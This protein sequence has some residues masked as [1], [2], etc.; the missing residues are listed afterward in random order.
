MAITGKPLDDPTRGSRPTNWEPQKD[1]DE[2]GN[3]R[4]S[5]ST[6][7]QKIYEADPAGG[8]DPPVGD[9][10]LNRTQRNSVITVRVHRQVHL[11]KNMFYTA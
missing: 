6:R 9:S 2:A 11:K 10:Q 8:H 7:K 4:S 1:S 5:P 3:Y